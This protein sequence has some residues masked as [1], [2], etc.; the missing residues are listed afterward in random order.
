MKHLLKWLGSVAFALLLVVVAIGT[1]GSASYAA[2]YESST[3]N[4]RVGKDR[5]PYTEEEI[6]EQLFDI[7]NKITIKIDM[8]DKEL[9]K[10]QDDYNAYSS[11]GSKSPIYRMANMTIRIQ[12][13]KSDY[14]YE[15]SQVGVRMKGNTSRIDFYNQSEGIYNLIHFKIDFQETFDDEEYYGSD[16][17]DW[18]GKDEEREARKD[19]TFATMEKLEMKWNRNYDNTYIREYYSYEMF[20]AN[21]VLAPHTNLASTDLSSVHLGVYM[22]YEPVDD[23]FI[24]KNLPEKEWGGDLYKCGWTMSPANFTSRVSIGVEDEDKGLFYNYDL[25]TNKKKSTHAEL[26]NLLTVL[27]RGTVTKEQY[28]SVVDVD[29]FVKFAACSYFTGNPDDMRNNYNNYYVYFLKSSGK[30]IMIPYDLDRCMGV[31]TGYNPT[32]NGNTKVSPFSEWAQGKGERQANPVYKYSVIRNAYYVDE[33]SSALI[34]VG[35]SEWMTT[36]HFNKY[37]NI[38]KKHYANDVK[39]SKDFEEV[40]ESRFFLSTTETA[41]IYSDDRNISFAD[42]SQA[43]L[44]KYPEELTVKKKSQK[45]TTGAEKYARSYGCNPVKLYAKTTG[46]GK[47]TYRSSDTKVVTVSSKGTIGV[48]GVGIATIT[49]TAG[50]TD[51]YA[52]ATK[53]VKITIKPRQQKLLSLTSTSKGKMTVKH[54]AD[55]TTTGFDIV[56]AT[57]SNFSNAKHVIVNSKT[58]MVKNINGLKSGK[59]YYVK[60]RAFKNT[61]GNTF[62]GNYSEKKSVV[63]R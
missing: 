59:R 40:D 53:T 62:Y 39:V 23:I 61:N 5:L 34:D 17:I 58:N 51:K 14:T 19:R 42:F 8:E 21:G 2:V 15:I 29:N 1:A 48:R 20:R 28:E 44:E 38:A 24:E 55:Y 46:D 52:M 33:Y 36:E 57:K 25:K 22:I 35:T 45:I 31:T 60:V 47:L 18:T 49:I 37:Y 9:Q 16:A 11:W 27:N 56:Y 13:N 32:G 4:I 41:P 12:T 63:I 7:N 43:V 50:Q 30:A 26:K 10:L 6:F 3:M 54:S